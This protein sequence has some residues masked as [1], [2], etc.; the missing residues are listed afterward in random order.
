MR[1]SSVCVCGEP[2]HSIGREKQAKQ[3]SLT[4][5]TRKRKQV[6]IRVWRRQHVA[7]VWE[8]NEKKYWSYY[9]LSFSFGQNKITAVISKMINFYPV[10]QSLLLYTTISVWEF[11]KRTTR[12]YYD[13]LYHSLK[14]GIC[15]A[16]I[17][18]QYKNLQCL[19]FSTGRL[20]SKTYSAE[21]VR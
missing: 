10:L 2:E 12:P 11:S 1:V 16:K 17:L 4:P 7:S 21:W 13:L 3:S 8:H 5:K 18:R 6:H 9:V 20:F 14:R 19:I 15:Q